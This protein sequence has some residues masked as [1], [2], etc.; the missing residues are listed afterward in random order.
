M[1]KRREQFD[2]CTFHAYLE[3]RITLWYVACLH[4]NIIENPAFRRLG[5]LTLLPNKQT[6]IVLHT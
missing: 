1:G 3:S 6:K 5:R 2:Y 4:V